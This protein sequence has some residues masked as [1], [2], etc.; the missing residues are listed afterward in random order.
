MFK[1]L[2]NYN[3]FFSP[4]FSFWALGLFSFHENFDGTASFFKTWAAET[5]K[6]II[7]I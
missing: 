1:I 4:L 5:T 3:I 2:S 6:T 7:V